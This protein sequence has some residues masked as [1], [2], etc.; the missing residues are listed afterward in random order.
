M[1]ILERKTHV[2]CTNICQASLKNIWALYL[3]GSIKKMSYVF[4][5]IELP[6]GQPYWTH[7]LLP[8]LSV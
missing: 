5:F 8:V 6:W 2:L 4:V 7:T 1:H 3:T